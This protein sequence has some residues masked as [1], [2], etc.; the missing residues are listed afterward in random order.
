[1]ATFNTTL[2]DSQGTSVQPVDI[3]DFDLEAYADYEAQLLESNRQFKEAEHGLLVYRRVRADGVFYDK[4]RDYKESLRLQLG[5]L[6]TSMQYKADIAN[7]LEPWY[8]IGYIAASFGADYKWP[9]GQAPAVDPPFTCAEDILKADVKPIAD[10]TI[11]RQILEMEEY[12]LE[13][14][15]GKLPISFCDIQAP[16]NMMSYLLPI[17]DLFMEIYDDPDS[18]KEAA[19]LCTNL[20]IEFLQKQKNLLGSCLASPGHGFASSRAFTGAGMSDDNSIMVNPEDYEEL[21]QPADEKIGEAFGGTVYHSCGTWENKIDMVKNIGHI[22]TVDG[23]FTIETDPSPNRPEIF[24]PAFENTGIVVNAR[25]VGNADT[26]FDAFSKLWTPNQKLIA[27][28][29]CQ[30][31]AE[32]EVLYNRLHEMAGGF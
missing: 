27:V 31:P 28:T 5:A 10:T 2:R 12:F 24:A 15:K 17:T 6:Q 9:E 4:C 25:A 21:F 13:Q 26:A 7:F 22:I 23:A 16:L 19:S 29:Y 30:D 1:M 18:V 8:G 14:T 32:Q 20:L 3:K 11:G